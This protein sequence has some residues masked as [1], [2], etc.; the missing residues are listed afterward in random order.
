MLAQPEF[1]QTNMMLL[2]GLLMTFGI[3]V[4]LIIVFWTGIKLWI[5]RIRQQRG[6]SEDYC[7]THFADGRRRPPR[8]EGICDSCQGAFGDVYY[9]PS[10]KKLCSRCYGESDVPP[11]P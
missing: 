3:L 10:G 1:F 2:L 4:V 8:G 9:L 7:R 11:A 6:R 5:F